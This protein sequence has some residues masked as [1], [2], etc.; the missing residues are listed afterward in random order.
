[1]C[2]TATETRTV[3]AVDLMDIADRVVVSA[4]HASDKAALQDN[5]PDSIVA[6]FAR[7]AARARILRD[8]VYAGITGGK[9]IDDAD[10][11]TAELESMSDDIDN[12]LIAADIRV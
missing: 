8:K 10:A 1:M 11:I 3:R 2:N 12:E 4:R 9:D 5:I 7:L 6:Y